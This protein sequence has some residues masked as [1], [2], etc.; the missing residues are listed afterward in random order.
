M[1]LS[2]LNHSPNIDIEKYSCGIPSAFIFAYLSLRDLREFS[3]KYSLLNKIKKM[4]IFLTS[5]LVSYLS[6]M[7][8]IQP[9]KL[10]ILVFS[11]LKKSRN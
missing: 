11:I 8:T 10:C 2:M 9:L 7:I 3:V 5:F 6:S 1:L 4:F